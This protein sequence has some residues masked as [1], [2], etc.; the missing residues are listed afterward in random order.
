VHQLGPNR[1]AVKFVLFCL[2]AG[3]AAV[4]SLAAL[5]LLSMVVSTPGRWEQGL[6]FAVSYAAGV[7]VNFALQSAW[8]FRAPN[9][10][11]VPRL[12]RFTVLN[13]AI[14][15]CAGTLATTLVTVCCQSPNLWER[16]LAL[17]LA[18]LVLA[19]IN[20]FLTRRLFA[21]DVIRHV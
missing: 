3:T 17:C 15:L 6:V 16:T 4:V 13:F 21:P 19:P 14:S 8:V 9:H 1:I 11:V 10:S 7:A 20:F 12:Y 5:V 18:A 2:S